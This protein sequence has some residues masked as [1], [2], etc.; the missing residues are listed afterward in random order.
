MRKSKKAMHNALLDLLCEKEYKDITVKDIA[1]KAMIN[2]KTFYFH[3]DTKQDLY[4]EIAQEIL[5]DISSVKLI[6]SLQNSGVRQQERIIF[7]LLDILKSHRRECLILMNDNT[8]TDFNALLKEKLQSAIIS[9]Q[10]VLARMQ[11][12]KTVIDLLT[13]VYFENFTKVLKWWL[14][15]KTDDPMIFMETVGML[16]S[17]KPLEVLG[18]KEEILNEYSNIH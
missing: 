5:Q 14:K 18:L 2:R 10:D 4:N 13:D 15:N 3:Y 1:E 12:D 6:Q 8:N 7:S 17:S 16:F 11:Y 9:T